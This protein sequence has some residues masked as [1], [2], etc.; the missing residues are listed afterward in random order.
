MV[1]R[2]G[3]P[4]CDFACGTYPELQAHAEICDLDRRVGFLLHACGVSVVGSTAR[5]GCIDQ[6]RR[7]SK[8]ALFLKLSP[9][10]RRAVRAY[11]RTAKDR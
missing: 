6:L 1:A 11:L 7:V 4:Q 10:R 2:L 9:K 8:S 5:R 3:C